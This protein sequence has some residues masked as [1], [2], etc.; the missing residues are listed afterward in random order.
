MWLF[1]SKLIKIRQDRITTQ[2]RWWLAVTRLDRTDAEYF[3][4]H[5]KF[6]WTAL[7]YTEGPD[8]LCKS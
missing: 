1:K 6:R 8:S 5:G 4:H 3:Y 7:S 2:P